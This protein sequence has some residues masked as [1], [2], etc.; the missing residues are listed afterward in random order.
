MICLNRPRG[1]LPDWTIR[2]GRGF[3]AVSPIACAKSLP[4][5]GHQRCRLE[6]Y[7]MAVKDYLDISVTEH[8]A[9]V[10]PPAIGVLR[11]RFNPYNISGEVGMSTAAGKTA[12]TVREAQLD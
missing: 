4:Y 2:G 5:I 10:R 8:A 9:I 3:E 12:A 1:C 7:R 11:E 6:P